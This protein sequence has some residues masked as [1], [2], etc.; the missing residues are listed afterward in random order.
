MVARMTAPAVDPVAGLLATY[1]A[2]LGTAAGGDDLVTT[3]GGRPARGALVETLARM[4]TG[5]LRAALAESHRFVQD[6]GI[7]Y[8]STAA[9]MQGRNWV[10]DPVP[11]VLDDVEWDRL[12]AGLAQRARLLDELVVDLY[13]ARKMLRQGVLPPAVVLGHPEFVRQADG[14]RLAG[15]RQLVLTATDLTRRGDGSWQVLSDR[16][17]APSGV[18]YAMANRRIVARVLAGLHRET[19]LARLRGF[20]ATMSAALQDVAPADVELPR[21]VLLTPGA[22]SETAYDQAFLATLLGLP[23]VEADDLVMRGGRVWIRDSERLEPVDVVLRRVDTLMSDPLELR[24]DSGLGVPGLIEASRRGRVA[25]VNPIGVGVLENAALARFL[26]A[27][28]KALLGEELRLPDTPTWWCGADAERAHVL[29]RL[30]DLVVR[31]IAGGQVYDG[32]RLGPGQRDHLAGRIAATPWAFV[33]H[34]PLQLGTAPV[35]TRSGLEPRPMSLRT[36]AV[37]HDGE[38]HFMP[39]GLGRVA[40]RPSEDIVS[41]SRGARAKDVWV[42]SPPTQIGPVAL[43]RIALAGRPRRDLVLAPRVADNLFWLGRYAE[44]AEG[45]ARLLAVADDLVEDF[46]GRP[47]V[48]LTVT[49]IILDAVDRVT[50]TTH[51]GSAAEP[52]GRLRAL[53]GRPDQPGTVA[54]AATRMVLAAQQVRDQLSLDTW[55]MLSRLERSLA[56]E[57]S[58]DDQLQ[59]QLARVL[60]SLLAWS[61]IMAQSMVRDEAWACLDAGC[62]VERAR[63]TIAL[64][65]ATLVRRRSEQV[66]W[67]LAEAVLRAGESLITHRRRTASG[68]GPANPVASGLHLLLLDSTNPRSVR[69]QVDQLGADLRLLGDGRLAASLE[70]VAERLA[71]ASSS[72][73]A[74]DKETLVLLLTDLRKALSLFG[75]DLNRRHFTRK[76]T[77]LAQPT[78]WSSAWQVV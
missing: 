68:Q 17:Q 54:F 11:V 64:V 36:F 76:A 77:Q 39:G 24:A 31:P 43:E 66:E 67:H 57:P 45:T 4:G 71:G 56:D 58:E 3:A 55:L 42:L 23:L 59:P 30:R 60:E 48:G 14:I 18:G 50:N 7:T 65:S 32:R 19:S 74:G 63:H 10:I 35:V 69:F 34:E 38:Y 41:N 61:G 75:D 73:L 40:Q 37:A 5:G 15:P 28:S 72:A 51:P 62:R 27:I 12:E 78:G 52:L 53:T 9:G 25:V 2:R 33:A 49:R 70:P 26:P 46:H 13:S 21:V 29:A 1:S 47:G 16:V 22:A 6:E 8:G 44:R 20:F